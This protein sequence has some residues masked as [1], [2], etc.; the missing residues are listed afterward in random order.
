MKIFLASNMDAQ[1][2]TITDYNELRSA[3]NEVKAAP[4]HL[5]VEIRAPYLALNINDLTAHNPTGLH[6]FGGEDLF[7]PG[8]VEMGP[9]DGLHI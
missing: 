2:A 3:F 1:I 5:A 6:C 4:F 7:T 8:W 9:Q